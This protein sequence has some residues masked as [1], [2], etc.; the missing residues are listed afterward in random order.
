MKA[1][2]WQSVLDP[3]D[4]EKTA[5]AVAGVGGFEFTVLPFGL[6]NA[7]QG[8]QRMVDKVFISQTGRKLLTYIDVTLVFSPDKVQHL[9]D[10]EETFESLRR[11]NLTINP[12]KCTFM[13]DELKFLGLLSQKMAFI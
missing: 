11:A 4:C 10:L 13:T 12:H 3:A 9:R 8:F 6:E 2:F 1:G 5:F 7:S